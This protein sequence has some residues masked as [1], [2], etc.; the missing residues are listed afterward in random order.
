MQTKTGREA[1]EGF[2]TAKKLRPWAAR[3]LLLLLLL[4][5]LPAFAG[6]VQ[7]PMQPTSL[8]SATL[9]FAE[10]LKIVPLK[11]TA[12]VARGTVTKG[13]KETWVIEI[14]VPPWLKEKAATTSFSPTPDDIYPY[15][16]ETAAPCKPAG[17]AGAAAAR[18]I[19]FM[20]IIVNQD[21]NTKSLLTSSNIQSGYECTYDTVQPFVRCVDTIYGD[22][23]FYGSLATYT[24]RSIE[25]VAFLGMVYVARLP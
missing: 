20:P 3:P 4:G 14:P 9:G 10:S 6:A 17:S 15:G 8:S 22:K 19:T 1:W 11:E 7:N 18:N 12:T 25:F 24:S 21:D 16:E 23:F 5:L 2:K 13:G